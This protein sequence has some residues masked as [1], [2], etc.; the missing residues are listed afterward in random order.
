M[1]FIYHASF[2]CCCFLSKRVWLEKK[3]VLNWRKSK[4][5]HMRDEDVSNR[6][7]CSLVLMPKSVHC[8]IQIH[9]VVV[10]DANCH[11]VRICLVGNRQLLAIFHIQL[12]QWQC[13]IRSGLL[14]NTS[15]RWNVQ[16][17]IATIH[18]HCY[19]CAKREQAINIKQF[20]CFCFVLKSTTYPDFSFETLDRCREIQWAL[21][22]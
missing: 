22:V 6:R 2:C 20:F 8:L 21:W 15:N 3:W 17:L 7:M 4:L 1:I 11:R 12:F 10:F 18:L 13:Q 16:R 14:L 9:G 19:A 5:V